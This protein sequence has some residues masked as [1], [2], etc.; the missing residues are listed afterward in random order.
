M[1]KVINPVICFYKRS[2]IANYIL[3]YSYF[4]IP[5]SGT[6]LLDFKLNHF[7][8]HINRQ[9]K[10]KSHVILLINVLLRRTQLS[11]RL[12]QFPQR[13]FIATVAAKISSWRSSCS[14]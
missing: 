11:Y 13:I 2:G 14:V 6:L 4:L 5:I 3:S 7:S 10:W 9:A 12:C 8:F 1:N